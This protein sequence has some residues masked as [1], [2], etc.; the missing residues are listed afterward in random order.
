MRKNHG[1]EAGQQADCG[2]ACRGR[3]PNGLGQ[4]RSGRHQGRQG[5]AQ[6]FEELMP[7]V[8]EANR[9][10]QKTEEQFRKIVWRPDAEGRGRLAG[11]GREGRQSPMKPGSSERQGTGSRVAG[12][13]G[14]PATDWARA[15]VR[16]PPSAGRRRPLCGNGVKFGAADTP[17]FWYRP[18]DSKK[19]RVIYADLSVRVADTPP[20][21]PI[22]A[23][24]RPVQ[25]EALA[26]RQ[27]PST[28]VTRSQAR[29]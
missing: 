2:I 23:G 18:K 6:K 9:K 17:I 7:M 12:V 8:L 10:K 3:R 29:V 16:Q 11:R 19:Y 20:N 13:H 5:E 26:P 21:V 28:T 1:R 22:A 15:G 25:C 4:S 14:S 24:A 27:E